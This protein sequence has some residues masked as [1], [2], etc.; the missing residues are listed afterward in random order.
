M[1][2]QGLPMPQ[3]Q[4]VFEAIVLTCVLYAVQSLRG[5]ASSV[6]IENLQK[7]FFQS[8]AVETCKC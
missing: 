1:K 6:D 2:K 7:L 3:P 8:Q 4:E 5:D